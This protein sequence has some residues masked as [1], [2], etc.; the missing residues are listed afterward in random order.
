MARR[1]RPSFSPLSPTTPA[2]AFL[3]LFEKIYAPLTTGLLP[4]SVEVASSNR[5]VRNASTVPAVLP[6]TLDKLIDAVG[7]KTA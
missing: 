1:E 7:L 3:A 6:T 4:V 2:L 5:N